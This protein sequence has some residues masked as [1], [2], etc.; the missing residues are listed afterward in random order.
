MQE[1]QSHGETISV[2]AESH[3]SDP[4]RVTPAA[5]ARQRIWLLLFLAAMWSLSTAIFHGGWS[6]RVVGVQVVREDGRPIDVVRG[7]ARG[8]LFWTP[9]LTLWFLAELFA[10]L[11]WRDWLDI[12]HRR[13]AMWLL[14]A[15]VYLWRA[16]AVL[17][18]AYFVAALWQPQRA[19]HDRILGTYLVPR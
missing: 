18:L 17:L 8:F 11:Y 7:A 4:L 14:W 15:S 9:I 12:E 19:P 10:H 3:Q 1:Q 6:F 5:Q 2:G 16:G 13:S